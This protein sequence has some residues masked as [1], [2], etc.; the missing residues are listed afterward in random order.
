VSR[1]VPL[2]GGNSSGYAAIPALQRPE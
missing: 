1:I 2:Q